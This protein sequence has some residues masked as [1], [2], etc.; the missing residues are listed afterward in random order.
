MPS[1]QSRGIIKSIHNRPLRKEE[2]DPVTFEYTLY[3]TPSKYWAP[4]T[5]APKPGEV[6]G[7]VKVYDGQGTLVREISLED[8]AQRPRV[9]VPGSYW[10][11]EAAFKASKHR[12]REEQLREQ[13]GTDAGGGSV[14]GGPHRHDG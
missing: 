9:R 7:P 6:Y 5:G 1:K 8:L 4:R 11:S 3:Q 14:D 13:S 2:I 10:M 12:T